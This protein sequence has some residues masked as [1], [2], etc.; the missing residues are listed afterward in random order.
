MVLDSIPPETKQPGAEMAELAGGKKLKGPQEGGGAGPMAEGC[1]ER[2]SL[3]GM[4][5][6]SPS[7]RQALGKAPAEA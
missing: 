7:Q 2:S 3:S 1:S 4:A 6:S 5:R